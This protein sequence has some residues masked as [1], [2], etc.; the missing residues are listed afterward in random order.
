MQVYK[1]GGASIS[2][3]TGVKN[4]T[5]IILKEKDLPIVVV[6]AMGKMTNAFEKL[7]EGFVSCNNELLT[8]QLNCIESYHREIIKD[9]G[10]GTSLKFENFLVE[11]KTLL[12]NSDRE[13]KNYD[14]WYDHIVGYGEMFSCS[15]VSDYI[16]HLGHE[17][18]LIESRKTIITD[19]VFREANIEFSETT[20]RL[21]KAISG[22][23]IHILQGFIAGTRRGEHTTLGRE[24]SDYTAAAV[25][26]MLSCD[27]VTIWKDVDGVLNCDPRIFS[28]CTPIP[29][30]SYIDAVELAFSGAQIIHPKTIKPLENKNIPLYVRS[31]INPSHPGTIISQTSDKIDN[32]PFVIVRKNQVLISIRPKDFSF[33]LEESLQDIFTILNHHRQKVNLIQGSAVRISFSVDKSRYFDALLEELSPKYKVKYNDGLELLTIRGR[34]KEIEKTHTEGHDIYIRQQTR[35]ALRLLRR[36]KEST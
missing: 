24:G 14:W 4:I 21:K 18:K 33:V 27:S 34:Y 22:T 2:T 1:F 28:D 20:K 15:I 9:L 12:Q 5:S 30:L 23:G 36:A 8:A 19:D 17:N 13:E 35:R 10:I 3:A 26:N 16:T 11:L 31:F 29:S 7:L 32:V 6:S 25:A